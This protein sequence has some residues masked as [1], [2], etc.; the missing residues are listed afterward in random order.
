ME[1]KFEEIYKLTQSELERLD[2]KIL[3]KHVIELKQKIIYILLHG[4]HDVIECSYHKNYCKQDHAC[5]SCYGLTCE[6]NY[7]SEIDHDDDYIICKDCSIKCQYCENYVCKK[8][9]SKKTI[10]MNKINCGCCAEFAV[11]G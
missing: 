2:S 6:K 10:N 3:A 9:I 4:D 7:C 1:Q 11:E 5:T 8:C